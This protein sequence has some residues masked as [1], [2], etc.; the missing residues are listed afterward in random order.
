ML[1]SANLVN[2][3]LSNDIKSGRCHFFWKFRT[4]VIFN[5]KVDYKTHG[6]MFCS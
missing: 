5:K 6:S 4:F 3:Q 1:N 2:L